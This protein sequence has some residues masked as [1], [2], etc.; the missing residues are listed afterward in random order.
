MKLVRELENKRVIWQV[1][2]KERWLADLLANKKA[3]AP[4]LK[5]LVETEIGVREGVRERETEWALKNDQVGEDL[6]G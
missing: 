6:L 4:L 2:A 5:F 1:Q 3:A